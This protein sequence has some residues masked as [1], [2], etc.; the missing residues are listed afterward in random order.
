MLLPGSR[1]ITGIN[2]SAQVFLKIFM[3]NDVNILIIM[4]SNKLNLLRFSHYLSVYSHLINF[5]KVDTSNPIFHERK[6]RLIQIKY[7]MQDHVA[8]LWQGLDFS[9]GLSDSRF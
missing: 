7:F 8:K 5:C 9:Q 2:K 3:S 1:G 6:L 4:I